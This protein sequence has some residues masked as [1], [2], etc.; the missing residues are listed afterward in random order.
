MTEET[1]ERMAAELVAASRGDRDD[2]EVLLADLRLAVEDAMAKHD[3]LS[4]AKKTA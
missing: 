3:S 1:I 2:L 4:R